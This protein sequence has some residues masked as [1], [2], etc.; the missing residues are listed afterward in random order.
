MRYHLQILLFSLIL[1]ASCKKEKPSK[2]E[3]QGIITYADTLYAKNTELI[4][5]KDLNK[6]RGHIHKFFYKNGSYKLVSNGTTGSITIYRQ[7]DS[8]AY[9]YSKGI[10]TLLVNNILI[11]KRSLD[12]MYFSGKYQTILNNR[13]Y[14]LIKKI[15]Q[16]TYKYNLDSSL[17]VNPKQFKAYKFAY[18]NEFYEVTKSLPLK[19]EYESSMFKIKSIATNIEHKEIEDSVF[20]IP[21]FPHKTLMGR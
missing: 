21:N 12:T 4:D 14:E 13:T 11:E 16:T 8:V 3:F 1:T 6:K 18:L 7:G 9:T 20:L 15:G 5:E 10:D 17:Y 2:E 19:E